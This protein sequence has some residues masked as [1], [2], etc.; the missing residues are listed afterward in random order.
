MSESA[1]S[2]YPANRRVQKAARLSECG[3]YRYWLGR[4]WDEADS[5]VFVML[6]PST[7][8]AAIDDPT[9]RRCMAFARREGYGGISVLNLYALRSPDPKA[10]LTCEDPVGP[11]NDGYLRLTLEEQ[12]RRGHPV[13]AAWGTNAKRERVVDVLT[14]AGGVFWGCLGTTKDGHPRHPLYVRGDQP[15]EGFI[16]R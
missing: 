15:I 1:R 3:R 8:D 7:A 10:L 2:G 4:I 14:L 12:A 5:L 13:I 9:I 16:Q 6:N 11:E